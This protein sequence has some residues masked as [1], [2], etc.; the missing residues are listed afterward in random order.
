[1]LLISILLTSWQFLFSV[2]STS[3][4]S[5][6]TT[7]EQL[8]TAGLLLSMYDILVDTIRLRVNSLNAKV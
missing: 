3:S 8:K 2:F 5:S 6:I 7:T 1:M 4:Y